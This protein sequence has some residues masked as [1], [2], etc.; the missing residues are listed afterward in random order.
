MAQEHTTSI[1]YW[2]KVH[3]LNLIMRKHQTTI[4]LKN[5]LQNA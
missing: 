1:V 5:I 4:I 3:S 2:E